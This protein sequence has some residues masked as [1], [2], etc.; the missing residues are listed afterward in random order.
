MD[1]SLGSIV[2]A[3]AWHLT[4]QIPVIASLIGGALCDKEAYAMIVAIIVAILSELLLPF[5]DSIHVLEIVGVITAFLAF[6]L[7]SQLAFR[8]KRL[9]LRLK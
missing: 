6:A 7:C 3:V 8:I 2:N 1:I 5:T 9:F 4:D